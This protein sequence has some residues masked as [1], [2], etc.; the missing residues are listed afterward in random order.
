MEVPETVANSVE[1]LKHIVVDYC[2]TCTLPK[3]YCEFSS[4]HAPQVKIADQNSEPD[5]PKKIEPDSNKIEEKKPEKAKKDKNKAKLQKIKLL[6]YEKK[7]RTLTQVSGF[8][9]FGV[10]GKE[11]SK[12]LTKKFGC[13]SGSVTSD[14]FELQ[15]AFN[16]SLVEFLLEEF[17]GLMTFNNFEIEEKLDKKNKKKGKPTPEDDGQNTGK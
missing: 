17:E 5:Q 12:K 2:P 10:S 14:G 6:L 9:L 13:G 8:D 11:V 1:K 15:G 7:G 3:E 4:L 16:E